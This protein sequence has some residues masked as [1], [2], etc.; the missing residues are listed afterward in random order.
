MNPPPSATA[1]RNG[2]ALQATGLV[3]HLG[4]RFVLEVPSLAVER[5]E[6]LAIIGPNGSGKSTLLQALALLVPLTSGELYFEGESVHPGSDLVALRRRMAVVFQEPLLLNMSVREN[7]TMGLRLRGLSQSQVACRADFWLQRFGIASLAMRHARALSGGEAQRA[8][9]ARAFALEPEVLFLDEPFAALDAPTR[10]EL[11]ES[12]V[13]VLRETGVTTVFVTHDR[14]EALALGHRVGVLMDGRLRQLDRPEVVF[15]APV[16]LEVAA[17]VGMETVLPGRVLAQEE[18][19]ALVQVSGSRVEVVSDLPPGREVLVC[20]RPEDVTLHA[21]HNGGP[22]SS[23]RNRLRGRVSRLSP[24]GA[25]VAVTVEC[26]FPLVATVTRRS[27]L[28]MA[29]SLG[30]Q[31]DVT[32]KASAAHLI[33]R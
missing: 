16:D 14:N 8:S 1:K 4:G 20:L 7:V 6:V 19:L 30:Q 27:A 2:P 10:A 18:S 13:T 5:G 22:S 32:F 23:A 25:L 26:G 24:R 11:I 28:D 33:P 17:F 9:L 3:V 12:L 15:G 29:L 31:V 21:P